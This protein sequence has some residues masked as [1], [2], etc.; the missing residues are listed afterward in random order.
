MIE[1][2]INWNGAGW[3]DSERET[4]LGRTFSWPA[5]QMPVRTGNGWKQDRGGK[6]QLAG[7]Q[8]Q[9]PVQIQMKIQIQDSNRWR[10][11]KA[12]FPFLLKGSI[13]INVTIMKKI[14]A[15]RTISIGKRLK[16]AAF[17]QGKGKPGKELNML[18]D[19]RHENMMILMWQYD[20]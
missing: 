4:W 10:P 6:V 17:S 20:D 19:D 13:N 2:V 5:G 3:C 12:G 18:Y 16:K 11:D 9:I 14:S 15:G 1:S 7:T 8:I